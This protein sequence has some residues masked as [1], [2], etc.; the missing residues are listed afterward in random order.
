MRHRVFA[1]PARGNFS[2]TR[3]FTDAHAD[4]SR[5]AA[6]YKKRLLDFTQAAPKYDGN[7]K[8]VFKWCKKLETYLDTHDREP[9][10]NDKVKKML[11]ACIMGSA[12]QEIVLLHASG[13]AF[14]NYEIGEFVKELLKKFSQEKD[15]EGR[16]QE[17]MTRKQESLEDPRKC[18]RSLV[19]F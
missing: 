2:E 8:T 17:Y 1:N 4:R 16:K 12:R 15:E 18:K 10:S 9:I 14:A 3:Y 6:E 11:L 19:E 5:A 13:L 7:P